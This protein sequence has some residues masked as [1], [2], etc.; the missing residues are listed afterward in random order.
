MHP[1][2]SQTITR[3]NL[4][5]SDFEIFFVSL[6]NTAGAITDAKTPNSANTIVPVT[7]PGAKNP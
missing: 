5:E 4:I 6:P 3:L 7:I 2:V 1:V